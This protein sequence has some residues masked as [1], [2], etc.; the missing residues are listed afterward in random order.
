MKIK[1]LLLI[2]TIFV[3]SII[4]SGC[5]IMFPAA[6]KNLV[7]TNVTSNSVSL[8]WTDSSNNIIGF[9]IARSSDG[10]NYVGVT[11]VGGKVNVYTDS[12]LKPNT[13]YFYKVRAYNKNGYSNWSNP[14]TAITKQVIP[15]APTNLHIIDVT[16]TSVTFSWNELSDNV[17]WF[18]IWRKSGMQR[19]AKCAT[20][21]ATT[22]KYTDSNLDQWTSY[23]YVVTAH[24]SAGDSSYSNMITPVRPGTLKWKISTGGNVNSS[25][26]IST[27]GNV[28]FASKDGYLYTCNS[29]GDLRYKIQAFSSMPIN[30]LLNLVSDAYYS[31]KDGTI[32][33]IAPNGTVKWT[34]QIGSPIFAPAIMPNGR[35]FFTAQSGSV[36]TTIS[37]STPTV[38]FHAYENIT[39]PIVSD[40]S[41]IY[42]GTT[43]GVYKVD[44]TNGDL[45]WKKNFYAKITALALGTNIIYVGTAPGYV[46]AIDT[47]SDGSVWSKALP[48]AINNSFVV[49]NNGVVYTAIGKTLY[50]IKGGLVLWSFKA[51]GIIHSTPAIGDDGTIYFGSNDGCLYAVNKDGKLAWTFQTGGPVE[52]SPAID[53]NGTI[54]FGSDDGYLY[55]INSQSRGLMNSSWPMYRG[56]A[57]HS[58]MRKD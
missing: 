43:N 41:Y 36:M 47:Q 23:S 48:G 24:N 55:A 51:N 7:V 37:G 42:F 35:I 18:T 31:T 21:S 15:S 56:N 4:L 52:T 22:T 11:S 29:I 30:I 34:F 17:D 3:L 25:P 53:T 2:T 5:F 13:T 39:T 6:P 33:N 1:M 32:S 26:S 46:Y 58:G 44:K 49:D 40:G 50:A 14:A 54:Y 10:V 12:N 20:V 8:Q 38:F 9:Q 45:V 16:H 19:F 28:Y 27:T 57:R